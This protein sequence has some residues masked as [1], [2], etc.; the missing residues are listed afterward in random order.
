[1][2]GN[3]REATIVDNSDHSDVDVNP[4]FATAIIPFSFPLFAIIATVRT[5]TSMRC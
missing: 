3:V 2:N 1:M 5:H 4:G